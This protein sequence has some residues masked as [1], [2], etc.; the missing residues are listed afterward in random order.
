[1]QVRLLLRFE[2]WE[3]ERTGRSVRFV[4]GAGVSHAPVTRSPLNRWRGRWVGWEPGVRAPGVSR[5]LLLR[6]LAPVM[7]GT[8]LPSL[9]HAT[10]AH[11]RSVPLV[12]LSLEEK[13]ATFESA[14]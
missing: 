7:N 1:M 9:C 11:R 3:A 8:F 14:V 12:M 4:D 5:N 6:V 10:S 2:L 13:A